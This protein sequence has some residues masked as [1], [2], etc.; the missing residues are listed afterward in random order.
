M[1]ILHMHANTGTKLLQ[2]FKV[3]SNSRT[4]QWTETDR[5]LDTTNLKINRNIC[6]RWI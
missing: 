2:C 6:D 1:M 3:I 5:V 4:R